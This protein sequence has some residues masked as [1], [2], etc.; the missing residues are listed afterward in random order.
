[1]FTEDYLMR[2]INQALAALLT[3]IGLKKAGKF[4]EA[5]QAIDQAVEGLTAMPAG[6][7]DQMD[8]DSLLSVLTVQDKLDV[9]RLAVLADLYQEQGEI[10]AQLGQGAEGASSSARALRLILEAVLA[11]EGD[12]FPELIGKIEAR[13]LA[14]QNNNLPI[15]TQLALRDYFQRLLAQD[16][17][18]LAVAG[19]SRALIA[20][21]L[22]ALQAGLGQE[23]DP[24]KR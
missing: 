16:D 21:A 19:T 9:A 23:L 12:L 18:S 7:L 3:A 13:R 10:L 6:L 20:A 2:M 5:R 14:A 15:Q 24:T 17:V 22:D 1:M 11:G 4:R 8:E